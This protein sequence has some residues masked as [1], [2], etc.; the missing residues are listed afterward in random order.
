MGAPLRNW[1]E[2]VALAD[3]RMENESLDLPATWVIHN[4]AKAVMGS[5]SLIKD[6]LPA[7][8]DLNPWLASL[9]VFPEFQ[10]HGLGR[11]LVQKAL[12][13]VRRHR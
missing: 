6:D 10:G 3:F 12:E 1:N 8:P 7:F 11:I 9:L 13:N 5:I 4:Q 2:A